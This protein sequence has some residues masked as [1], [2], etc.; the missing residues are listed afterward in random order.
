MIL[1]LGIEFKISYPF[2]FFYIFNSIS[3][4]LSLIQFLSLTIFY[5]IL[6]VLYN[7]IIV[8]DGENDGD[9]RVRLQFM[10]V[11]IQRIFSMGKLKTFV[12]HVKKNCTEKI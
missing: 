10:L 5:I 7:K 6:H 8:T 3:F 9:R 1:N 11:A 2:S 4:R 12:Y